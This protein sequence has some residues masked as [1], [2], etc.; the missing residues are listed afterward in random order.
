MVEVG[1]RF[2]YGQLTGAGVLD[3]VTDE[4]GYQ[5]RVGKLTSAQDFKQIRSNGGNLT[6][7]LICAIQ[8]D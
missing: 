8:I 1:R 7:R 6:P 5:W 4:S 2:K 3:G